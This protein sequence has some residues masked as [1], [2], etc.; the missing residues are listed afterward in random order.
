MTIETIKAAMGRFVQFIN[1]PAAEVNAS[2]YVSENAIFHVPGLAEPLRGPAGYVQILAMLRTGFPDISWS[3]DQMVAEGDWVAARFSS[4]G[5]H[6]GTIFGVA[7]TGNAFTSRAMA[8]YRFQDGKLIEE[9][10]LPDFLDLLQQIG[11]IPRD[12]MK[13][14]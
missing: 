14:L 6:L 2:D 3:V 10:A 13:G 7:A 1:S 8:F 4:R 12:V 9:F 11:A 5:T